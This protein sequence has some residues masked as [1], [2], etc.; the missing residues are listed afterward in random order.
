MI[1]RFFCKLVF[2]YSI[3]GFFISTNAIS[4]ALTAVGLIAVSGLSVIRS[5]RNKNFPLL[6]FSLFVVTYCIVPFNYLLGI[7]E[8]VINNVF[9][10]E[11]K[12]TVF[13]SAHCLLTFMSTFLLTARFDVPNYCREQSTY[14]QINNPAGFSICLVLAIVCVI[15]GTTGENIFES[16]GYAQ[17]NSE[18]SSLYEYGII[19]I[20]LAL[21][22]S[23]SKIQTNMVYALCLFFIIKDL[24]HG[25][26]ISSVMLILAIFML[27]YL[28]RFSFIKVVACVVIGYI[29]FQFWGYYR[30]SMSSSGFDVSEADGNAQYVVYASMRI[31]YMIEEGVL[32]WNNRIYSFICFLLSA[33]VPT[34]NLPALANL[35]SYKASEY[36]TGGGGLVSTFLYCWA[37]IPGIVV[38]ARWVGKSVTK[39]FHSQ[40][41]Y[42]RFYALLLIITTPRWFAYYP[43]QLIKYT[44][45]G[46]LIFYLFNQFVK[47]T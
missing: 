22:Y 19:F 40:S 12:D 5:A 21:I 7:D 45:Y 11:T 33:F 20:S 41:V 31:H 34:S 25:G 44:I 32:N 30:S 28:N 10:A 15:L 13:L 46:V 6:V 24:L 14:M 35:S 8:H 23:R 47:R 3:I 38:V 43:S 2:A 4:M 26:R 16:G 39:F 29:F 18:R 1:E 27:R 42:W 9:F 36:Y 17:G 37:W